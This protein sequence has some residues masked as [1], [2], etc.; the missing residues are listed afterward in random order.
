MAKPYSFDLR[1]RVTAAVDRDGMSRQAAA[2]RF[3]V[4]ASTAIHW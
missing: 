1:E 3:G 4:A 2:R